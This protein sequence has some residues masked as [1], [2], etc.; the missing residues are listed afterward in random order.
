MSIILSVHLG[1]D[2]SRP[3]DASYNFILSSNS[4]GLS[5]VRMAITA[6]INKFWA[7]PTGSVSQKDDVKIGCAESV[8]KKN[9][10]SLRLL[11]FS[12]E[13]VPKANRTLFSEKAPLLLIIVFKMRD[14]S[15]WLVPAH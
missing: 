15:K 3:R 4:V 8:D 9:R 10:A 11:I 12:P 13:L 2:K 7:G 5:L 6:F 14:G 1:A